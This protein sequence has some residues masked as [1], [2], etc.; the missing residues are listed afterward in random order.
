MRR[1]ARGF[2][3][4]HKGAV[5]NEWR[6]KQPERDRSLFRCHRTRAEQGRETPSAATWMRNISKLTLLKWAVIWCFGG[7][8]ITFC[9]SPIQ[10]SPEGEDV[11]WPSLGALLM[12]CSGLHLGS[13]RTIPPLCRRRVA[14]V[15]PGLLGCLSSAYMMVPQGV[16]S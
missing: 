14:E 15:L 16:Q 1:A 4:E 12:L 2:C 6:T 11:K 7:R 13:A 9:W 3:R 10:R 8:E 5:E